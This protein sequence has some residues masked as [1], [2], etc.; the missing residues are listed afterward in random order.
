M[1]NI[2]K[3]IQSLY[4]FFSK[5]EITII[6]KGRNKINGNFTRENMEI[7]HTEFAPTKN[8]LTP[9]MKSYESLENSEEF[10]V[11]RKDLI[12]KQEYED[13]FNKLINIKSFTREDKAI[14][15]KN[16][17]NDLK[18]I[19]D[20]LIPIKKLGINLTIDL[21]GGAV[22]DFVLDKHNLISDLDV[23]ISFFNTAS[24]SK[25]KF[26]DFEKVGITKEILDKVKWCNK[27]NDTS[28]IR[29]KL[30][31]ACFEKM[32]MVQT[33]FIHKSEDRNEN[34]K[35]AIGNN[36]EYIDTVHSRLSGVIKL[37]EN[38]L[39]YKVDLLI[40]DLIKPV[41]LNSFDINLCKA[42][43]SF[44]NTN[45]KKEFPLE[46]SH[47]ISRFDAS[48]DFFADIHNKKLT[49]DIGDR[50]DKMMDATIDDHLPKVKAKY[51]DYEVIFISSNEKD[52]ERLK[53]IKNQ[54]FAEKLG[55]SLA[56][57]QENKKSIKI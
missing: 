55:R 18:V 36:S 14:V 28:I 17:Y 27:E 49:I 26:K 13:T 11:T 57:K 38:T 15:L 19:H 47:L 2:K 21:T 25:L 46:Y 8:P 39:N 20:T 50:S 48:I 52:E 37:K 40:T 29:T 33:C 43:I 12:T 44:L 23:M 22:R 41:F 3:I 32:N 45:Y 35:R 56:K 4:H 51:P 16:I 54:Y 31:Q 7:A 53:K 6:F 42:S 9:Y 10:T 5:N 1:V 24:S 30:I 34:V